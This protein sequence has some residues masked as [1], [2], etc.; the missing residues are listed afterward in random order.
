[1]IRTSF[2]CCL[3]AF[4][5]HATARAAGDDAPSARQNALQIDRVEVPS[6]EPAIL[7]RLA[8]PLRFPWSLAFVPNGGLLITEKHHG[9]RLYSQGRLSP[10][11]IAGGPANVLAKG[12]SGLLDI[13]V[14]PDFK[15]T[16]RVFVAFAE[17]TPERNRTAV[18]TARLVDNRF[19]DGRV[20][21]RSTP[22]KK[23]QDH[24]GGRLLFLAD[25]T[26]LLT[27]GD[28]YD[29]RTSAQDM[30]SHLGKTLR[31]TRDGK[32]PPDNPF[33]NQR[34][35]L[36]EIYSLGHRN[37]QGLTLDPKTRDIW[38]HEHG[39]RGG[40]EIGLLLAGRNYG[41]PTVTFGI[42]YDGKLISERLAAPGFELPKFFWAPS[43]AP[44]GLAIY[45]GA[46]FPDWDGKSLIGGLACRCVIVLRRGKETGLLLEEG[47]Y[48]SGLG[49]R[50]R[51]VRVGPDSLVYL[52]TDAEDGQLLRWRPK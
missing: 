22:D 48:L 18:W 42:D 27:V 45:R 52:L 26:F 30:G 37:A 49:Y 3:L 47:R 4:A 51:D 38:L 29:Y 36:P 15:D 21:F 28:G 34:G 12:D 23:G 31:L 32:A 25:G 17:G 8:S 16:Q 6:T 1:M 11:V 24:P 7:E 44:S 14:D 33:V 13:V 19:V 35:A 43:I 20:I 39:P 9:V 41:W 10:D 5:V 46:A 50:F 40:D 2:V